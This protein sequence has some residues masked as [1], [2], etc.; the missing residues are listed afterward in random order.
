MFQSTRRFTLLLVLVIGPGVLEMTGCSLSPSLKDCRIIGGTSRWDSTGGIYRVTV[1]VENGA[2]Q[3]LDLEDIVFEITTYDSQNRI[4]E[5]NYSV[6]IKGQIDRY[7][8]DTI[9]LNTPDREGKITR[10]KVFMK[11]RR[12][13]IVSEWPASSEKR[14]TERG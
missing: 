9:L 11:D 2:P 6:S 8:N 1:V 10:T 7:D 12:G 3:P 13:H 14:Q 5:S 4:L